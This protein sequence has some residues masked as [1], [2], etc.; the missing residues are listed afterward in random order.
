M[1]NLVPAILVKRTLGARTSK[2]KTLDPLGSSRKLV[3]GEP[4]APGSFSSFFKQSWHRVLEEVQDASNI[5]R[6][7]RR[8]KEPRAIVH[9]FPYLLASDYALRKR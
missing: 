5:G 9:C 2:T 8:F 1:P 3:C 6:L 7:L 4:E